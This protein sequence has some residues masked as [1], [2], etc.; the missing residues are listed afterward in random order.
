MSAPLGRSVIAGLADFVGRGW[1]TKSIGDL[2]SKIIS[3][4]KFRNEVRTGGVVS[5][6]A[7][8]S[9]SVCQIDT[10]A[11]DCTLNG[12]IKAQL[13]ALND[14]D[15]F[16]TSGSIGQPIFQN[17]ATA[18][19]ISLATDETAHMAVIACNTNGAGGATDTD[20]GAVIVMAVV[21]GTA[22]TYASKTAPPSSVEIQAALDASTG[23]HAGVTGWVWL[24]SILW[25]ENSGSPTRT[26]TLNRN[27]VISEL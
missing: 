26:I 6:G 17:G 10:T 13:A 18:A 15:L 25:D 12:R 16:T 7:T 27:N 14:A 5:N 19:A 21:A 22:T 8:V 9:A 1:Y 23:V 4:M 20:N 3:S 24:A 2:V 11:L